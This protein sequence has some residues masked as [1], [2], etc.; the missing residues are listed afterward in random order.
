[1]LF[2]AHFGG[3]DWGAL[4]SLNLAVQVLM[5]IKETLKNLKK[6]NGKGVCSIKVAN[7]LVPW[8]FGVPL[9]FF[10]FF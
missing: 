9:G 4:S 10:E 8:S 5:I 6:P 3:Y 7:F 1:M 2:Y